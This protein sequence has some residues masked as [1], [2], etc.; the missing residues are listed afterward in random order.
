MGKISFRAAAKRAKNKHDA[1]STH[2]T[3]FE[4]GVIRPTYYRPILA[5]DRIEANVS[6]SVRLSPL[7]VPTFGEF[8]LR[9]SAFFCSFK[10]VW[11]Y[12]DKFKSN[13]Q[14][15]F[16]QDFNGFAP[17]SGFTDAMITKPRVFRNLLVAA[18]L[19]GNDFTEVVNNPDTSQRVVSDFIIPISDNE[20]AGVIFTAK[21]RR[22]MNIFRG[23]GYVFPLRVNMVNDYHSVNSVRSDGDFID[24]LPLLCYTKVLHDHIY[25]NHYLESLK[26]QWFTDYSF[27]AKLNSITDKN[28]D[29][30]YADH[31]AFNYAFRVS[32]GYD[33]AFDTTYPLLSEIHRF[34]SE[35]VNI[36]ESFWA[37]N[38]FT[39]AW[40]QPNSV[41]GS[42][43]PSPTI[44]RGDDL[45]TSSSLVSNRVAQYSSGATTVVT[46][47]ALRALQHLSDYVTRY[48]LGGTHLR[49]WLDANFGFHTK[50]QVIDDSVF[51]R[52]MS[53]PVMIQDVTQTS[54]STSSSLLGEQAGKGF[55]FGNNQFRFEASQDGAII[56]LTELVPSTGY[57]QGDSYWQRDKWLPD[58]LDLYQP[59]FDNLGMMPIPKSAVRNDYSVGNTFEGSVYSPR[60]VFGY[61]PAYAEHKVRRDVLSG[62]FMFQS[63]NPLLRSRSG[64]IYG[65]YHTFRFFS[66]KLDGNSYLVPPKLGLDFL[67]QDSQMDRIFAAMPEDANGYQIYDHFYCMFNFDVKRYSIMKT[68]EQSIPFFNRDGDTISVDYNGNV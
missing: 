43:V 53:Q 49:Q 59:A 9:H 63:Q 37:H 60:S 19:Y 65:C 20:V 56:V 26:F 45:I 2:V 1:S 21:G 62:Q 44:R 24:L 39:D 3:T 5:G 38:L 40:Q 66:D 58:Y 54:A 50:E 11:P 29:S 8:T 15:E 48:N 68:V 27:W 61:A 18:L 30:W 6:S 13:D 42:I 51:I 64:G 67:V 10:S 31:A 57:V 46:D 52:S 16:L 14:T 32:V 23:L 4:S 41:N 55:S 22:L 33:G 47:Y 7:V 25:D 17:I 35:V 36:S 34:L 12:Y 28:L